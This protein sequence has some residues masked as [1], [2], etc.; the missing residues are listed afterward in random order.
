MKGNAMIAI[1]VTTFSRSPYEDVGRLVYQIYNALSTNA[2]ISKATI[3]LPRCLGNISRG[4]YQT[5]VAK[6]TKNK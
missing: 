5:T 2:E 1:H 6:S 3:S 4:Y